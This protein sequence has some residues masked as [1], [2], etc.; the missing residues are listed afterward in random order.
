MKKVISIGLYNNNPEKEID[1]EN[2]EEALSEM[3]RKEEGTLFVF[4]SK[5]KTKASVIMCPGG[6]YRQ[7]NLRHEGI[8]FADWFEDRNITYAILKYRY[9]RGNSDIPGKDIERAMKIMRRRFPEQTK[10]TGVMGASIG[11][12][13]AAASATTP[14]SFKNDFQILMYSVTSMKDKITHI[15]CKECILGNNPS[16]ADIKKY[17]P[18]EHVSPN[19]SPAFIVASADD[20]AVNPLNSI[21][22][23]AELQ[24][25]EVPV[26]LHIYPSGGHSFG[27]RD[28]Y[29]YKEQ[30]LAELDKWLAKSNYMQ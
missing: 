2:K 22:Y 20:P 4:N 27:F 12:Y 13:Y 10:K 3:E 8:D 17:S 5:Q 7:I 24:K 26:S 18:L 11:G 16:G 21:L 6:G 19:T 9:P 23:A 28:S 14:E 1:C 15:H 30:W 25:K 29:P